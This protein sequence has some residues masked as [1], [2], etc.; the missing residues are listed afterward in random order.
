M[1]EVFDPEICFLDQQEYE[2]AAKV[3]WLR[4]ALKEGFDAIARGEY[5]MLNSD[6]E[7][8]AFMKSIQQEVSLSVAECG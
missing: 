7:L 8:R 1:S 5:T 6:A 2:D 3:K 4:S